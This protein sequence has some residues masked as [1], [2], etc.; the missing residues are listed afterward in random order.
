MLWLFKILLRKETRVS[1]KIRSTMKESLISIITPAYNCGELILETYQSLESQTYK[2]IEWIIVNDASDD[3][4]TEQTIDKIRELATFPVKVITN[5]INQRQAFSKNKG[6]EASN[7][8]FVRFLDA[9]DLLSPQL[10]E[11]QTK[12]AVENLRCVIVSPTKYFKKRVN[13]TSYKEN[14]KYAQINFD[15]YLTTKFLVE[16]FFHHSGCL[17]PKEVIKYIGGFD[18]GLFTDEDGWLL[19]KLMLNDYRF[20]LVDDV[21][22]LYRKHNLTKRVSINDNPRKWRDRFRVCLL[23]EEEATR[24]GKL[25]LYKKELAQRIDIIASQYYFVNPKEAMEMLSKAKEICED[26]I[27]KQGRIFKYVRSVLGIK[28]AEIIRAFYVGFRQKLRPFKT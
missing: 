3:V 20:I 25:H 13:I 23:F 28:N 8:E 2:N 24:L 6:F 9:D 22:F 21:Y 11:R 12:R 7:G 16:P 1:V 18:D 19:L 26:Y 27:P 10:I 14:K 4:L 15:K 5:L 17:F